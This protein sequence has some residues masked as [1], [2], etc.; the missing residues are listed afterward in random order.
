MDGQAPAPPRPR[1][2]LEASLSAGVAFELTPKTTGGV[3]GMVGWRYGPLRIRV[4]AQHWVRTTQTLEP[5]AGIVAGL[6]GAGLRT[7][8]AVMS[9]R[10]EVPLCAG[11]DAAALH[12]RG[13]GAQV[14]GRRFAEPWVAAAFE[15]GFEVGLKPRVSLPIRLGLVV[16]VVRSRV[17]LVRDG[18]PAEVFQAPVVGLRL[19]AGAGFRSR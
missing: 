3:E 8:Y 13:D 19:V 17:H 14:S 12:G 6:S 2:G 18:T 11:A 10:I 15:I 9:S 4:L 1:G 5:E 7:C 16:P